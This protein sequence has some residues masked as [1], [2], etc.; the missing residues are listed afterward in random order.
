[1]GTQLA[2]YREPV[3]TAPPQTPQRGRVLGR[4]GVLEVGVGRSARRRIDCVSL[5]G[6][7]LN[8]DRLVLPCQKILAARRVD[9]GTGEHIIKGRPF[10]VRF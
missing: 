10:G 9:F 2:Q 6:R 7:G 8:G 3:V 4:T 1:M 5:V